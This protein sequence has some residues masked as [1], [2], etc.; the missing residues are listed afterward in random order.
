MS[1]TQ[2]FKCLS[3]EALIKVSGTIIGMLHLGQGGL[4]NV[5]DMLFC[6]LVAWIAKYYSK[7]LEAKHTR[8]DDHLRQNAGLLF[9][10]T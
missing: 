8:Y 4:P 2:T 7:M 9:C 1:A 5:F 6:S 3:I 10:K